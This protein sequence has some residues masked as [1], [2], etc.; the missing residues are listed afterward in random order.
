MKFLKTNNY[1]PIFNY[2]IQLFKGK[3]KSLSRTCISLYNEHLILQ[4]KKKS[5]LVNSEAMSTHLGMW[6]L[7]D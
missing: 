4:V 1:L 5:L 7:L 3:E 6:C 2:F